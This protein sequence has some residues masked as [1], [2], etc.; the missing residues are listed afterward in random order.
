M[1][2]QVHTWT[3]YS[4]A[5]GGVRPD[6]GHFVRS[7]WE[8]NFARVLLAMGLAYTY[9][10]QAFRT[11]IGSYV[12]DFLVPAWGAYVEVKGQMHGK[13]RRK[14]DA[15]AVEHPEVRLLVIDE[16]TYHALRVEWA[17]RIPAWETNDL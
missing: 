1:G 12:P 2:T 11:S 7:G 17:D 3:T 5:N 6:L 13:A 14:M 16:S 8:A 9:E 15:L 10:P 4:F